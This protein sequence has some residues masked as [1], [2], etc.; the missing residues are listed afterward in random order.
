MRNIERVHPGVG[1]DAETAIDVSGVLPN[2]SAHFFGADAIYT[3]FREGRV[4]RIITAFAQRL[5]VHRNA[6]A[7]IQSSRLHQ[8]N[9]I[10]RR[11]NIEDGHHVTHAGGALIDDQRMLAVLVEGVVVDEIVDEKTLVVELV[12]VAG[13]HQLHIAIVVV[14]Q[15]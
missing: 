5:L 3:V 11:E 4:Q 14:A 7:L 10:Y 6:V 8:H 12:L 15:E 9:P 2:E 13:E 1:D